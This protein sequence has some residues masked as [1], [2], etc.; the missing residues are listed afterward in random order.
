MIMM[1]YH[2]K[3][4]AAASAPLLG[5]LFLADEGSR[6]LVGC[7]TVAFAI[8]P[9]LSF[10]GHWHPQLSF[11]MH[12]LNFTQID[13]AFAEGRVPLLLRRRRPAPEGDVTFSVPVPGRSAVAARVRSESS[14]KQRVGRTRATET[15]KAEWI[16]RYVHPHGEIAAGAAAFSYVFFNTV[17]S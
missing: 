10:W 17:I 7:F 14:S 3:L 2:F 9:A 11:Q 4:R 12:S 13:L 15:E 6:V 8:L 1:N 16:T 5:R